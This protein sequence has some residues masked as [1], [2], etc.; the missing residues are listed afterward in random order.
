MLN[1]I[2]YLKSFNTNLSLP[3]FNTQ[4]KSATKY[5]FI[6]IWL[7]L[8]ASFSLPQFSQY[9]SKVKTTKLIQQ[10]HYKKVQ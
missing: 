1:V 6:L 3:L 4:V 2:I 8:Y 10:H 5:A 9:N 7:I